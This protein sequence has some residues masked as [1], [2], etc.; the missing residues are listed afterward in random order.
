MMRRARLASVVTGSSAAICAVLIACCAT[1]WYGA[2]EQRARTRRLV[3]REFPSS[4]AV[5]ELELATTMSGR[6]M[7]AILSDRLLA[8][9]GIRDAALGLVDGGLEKAE[10]AAELWNAR[11]HGPEEDRLW[12]ELQP[13]IA[14]WRERVGA[15][16][17]VAR[18]AAGQEAAHADELLAGFVDARGAYLEIGKGIAALKAA[19]AATLAREQA[20]AEAFASRTVAASIAALA[21]ALTLLLAIAWWL[22]AAVRRSVS[23]LERESAALTA[24]VDRGELGVRAAPEAIGP[25]FRPVLDGMNR[26]MDAIQRPI[27]VTADHVTR[28]ARGELPPPITDEYRGDFDRIK[29][30]LNACAA[31]VSALVRDARMLADAAIEGRLSTRGDVA[32]HEGEFR[33]VVAG[34]NG[35]LDANAAPVQEALGVLSRLAGNDLRARMSGSYAGEHE[36]VKAAVNATAEALH[37]ALTQV[38]QAVGQVS[39]ASQQIASSSQLVAD[40]ASE[41]ASALEET[42]S[43]LQS[44]SSI[45]QRSTDA[46]VQ[47]N[48]LAHAAKLA[49]T[50]G[51]AAMER[52]TGAMGR[53]RASAEGTS[54][55]IR[56]ID[57][58]AFQTNLLALNAAVEAARAGDAGRGFAVVAEEVRSLA[59]RSKEAATRTEA[60]IRQAVKEAGEGEATSGHVSGKLS[61]I[62]AGVSKVADIV[63]ELSASAKEQAQG[64]AQVTQAVAQMD[65]VTQG[66][67]A[68]SEES[69]SAAAELAGQAEELAAIVAAFQ[70]ERSLPAGAAEAPRVPAPPWRG[71]DGAQATRRAIRAP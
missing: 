58:I 37:A 26:T 22:L 42:S 24:A 4:V 35:M 59:L 1:S 31:N 18:R 71:T 68:S 66:N 19:S 69:S 67:A 64:I 20:D 65:R 46:A 49:A 33:A 28:I 11:E 48:G 45:T 47:A 56:D 3:E 16:R 51:A 5:R 34:V 25:D 38:A 29:R 30:A 13:T 6:G 40:G 14:R 55:I 44:M 7:N 50:E 12:R 61:D 43:Q 57:E 36:R 23:D 53:I 60:L 21:A 8:M 9:P 39:S 62:V 32:R 17:D 27:A 15:F 41:Q 54:A 10:L 70:L 52:M 2:H 63:A